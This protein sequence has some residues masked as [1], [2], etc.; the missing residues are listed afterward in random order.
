M[1]GLVVS[2]IAVGAALVVLVVYLRTRRTRRD[3]EQEDAR[4][5]VEGVQ[6]AANLLK[7]TQVYEVSDEVAQ[8]T[9]QGFQRERKPDKRRRFG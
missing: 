7:A 1:D 2:A 4:A 5:Q 6:G 3:R 8:R 9:A